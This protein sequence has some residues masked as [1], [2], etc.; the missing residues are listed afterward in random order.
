MKKILSTVLCAVLMFG[1][2]PGCI[3]AQEAKEEAKLVYTINAAESCKGTYGENT[4]KLEIEEYL[5]TA[6]FKLTNDG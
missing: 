1:I 3:D 2:M 6:G 5:M 4:A